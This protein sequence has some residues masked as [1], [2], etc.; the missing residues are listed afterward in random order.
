M[1]YQL[2][3]CEDVSMNK[4]VVIIAFLLFIVQLNAIDFAPTIGLGATWLEGE[5]LIGD[6]VSMGFA[7]GMAVRIGLGERFHLRSELLFIQKGAYNYKLWY[8]NEHI[9]EDGSIWYNPRLY[10]RSFQQ[11]YLNIPVILE[12]DITN[13]WYTGIGPFFDINISPGWMDNLRISC[14]GFSEYDYVRLEQDWAGFEWGALLETGYR[15]D[16]LWLL[17]RIDLSLRYQHS[18]VTNDLWEEYP[19]YVDDG[20]WDAPVN[21]HVHYTSHRHTRKVNHSNLYLILRYW[22]K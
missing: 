15:F 1:A 13:N 10:K 4:A 6:R 3:R 21:S 5:N 17:R 16:K 8:Y 18:F 22:L 20:Y 7:G 11:D 12:T 2:S 14:P 19:S 9:H